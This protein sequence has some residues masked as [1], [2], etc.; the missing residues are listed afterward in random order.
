MLGTGKDRNP[1]Q[2]R[3]DLFRAPFRM[4]MFDGLSL[5]LPHPPIVLTEEAKLFL[6][7]H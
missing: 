1:R 3:R 2:F 6:R 7:R 4:L 5:E